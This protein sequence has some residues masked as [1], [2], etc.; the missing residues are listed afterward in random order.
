[1][2]W[3]AKESA[4]SLLGNLAKSDST[5]V[6][7]DDFAQAVEEKKEGKNIAYCRKPDP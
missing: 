4:F 2:S 7:P 5:F 6:P 1:M 3:M